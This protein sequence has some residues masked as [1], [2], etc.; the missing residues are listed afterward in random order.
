MKRILL[1][2]ALVLSLS[3]CYVH[4]GPHAVVVRPVAPCPTAVWVEGHYNSHGRWVHPHWQC[5][6]VIVIE[7]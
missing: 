6:G 4:G 2:V 5:P 7:E 1:A 3:S